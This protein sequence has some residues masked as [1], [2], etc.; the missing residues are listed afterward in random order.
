MRWRTRRRR[1]RTRTRSSRRRKAISVPCMSAY[2]S[3]RPSILLSHYLPSIFLSHS[4]QG[5]SDSLWRDKAS[6]AVTAGW[7][8]SQGTTAG[9]GAGQGG[10]RPLVF[11]EVV[12]SLSQPSIV[13]FKLFKFSLGEVD[14]YLEEDLVDT[15]ASFLHNLPMNDLWQ[16]ENKGGLVLQGGGGGESLRVGQGAM[17]PSNT[18]SRR[19]SSLFIDVSAPRLVLLCIFWQGWA[20]QRMASLLSLECF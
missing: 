7:P 9:G 16:A 5:F 12:Q 6:Q 4:L 2:L 11:V 3:A 13:Y 10:E 15:C 1:R 18:L 19:T 8:A 14:L 17:G 20:I